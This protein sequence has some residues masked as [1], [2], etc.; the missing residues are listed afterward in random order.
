[1][2]WV[3][4]DFVEV[5]MKQFPSVE[6]DK[7]NPVKINFEGAEVWVEP[8]F[9]DVW[10]IRFVREG[11]EELSKLLILEVKGRIKTK[12]AYLDLP[13]LIRLESPVEIG[14]KST[15]TFFLSLPLEVEVAVET[16]SG[17]VNIEKIMPHNL[18]KAW[19]GEPQEGDLTYF[20]MSPVFHSLETA[21]KRPGEALVPV[22]MRN[23]DESS[24]KLE[25]LMVDSYQLSLYEK[26]EYLVTE[27][28][29]VVFL[30]GEAEVDY[31]D[32]PPYSDCVEIVKGEES[33]RK[34][35]LMRFTKRRLSKLTDELLGGIL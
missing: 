32:E 13:V 15:K 9:E 4:F 27:V 14:P 21:G 33:A 7:K 5:A 10:R 29:E 35:G 16:P 28:I 22:R 11:E 19:Y 6:V 3:L 30:D 20:F 17:E 2:E 31:T 8:L 26:D 34:R 24:R 12:P 25:K 23:M 1:V 18:K